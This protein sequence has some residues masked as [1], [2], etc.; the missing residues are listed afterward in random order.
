MASSVC[1][2]CA[3]MHV[4]VCACTHDNSIKVWT[5][6]LRRIRTYV[7]ECNYFCRDSKH[8]LAGAA[9]VHGTCWEPLVNVRQLIFQ[10]PADL[11]SA[12][13]ESGELSFVLSWQGKYAKLMLLY[14][15]Y[16]VLGR[17]SLTMGPWLSLTSWPPP[18][19]HQ[20]WVVSLLP[21]SQL[22]CLLHFS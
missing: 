20:C 16:E 8:R 5:W 19:P 2:L 12:L 3:R 15:C 18:S 7:D 4:C 9:R 10:S 11:I 21:H 1:V 17:E 22:C 13:T 14:C 6:K